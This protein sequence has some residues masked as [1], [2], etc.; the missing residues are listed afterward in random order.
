MRRLLGLLLL[1]LIASGFVPGALC[2]SAEA[3][4]L[5]GEPAHVE[6]TEDAQAFRYTPT[7]NGLYG[8]YLM[9][10]TDGASGRAEIR[11]G[12][13]EIVSDEGDMNVLSLRMVAGTE[14]E[15]RLS[16]EGSVRLEVAREALS[17]SFSMPLELRD[18]GSYSKLIAR[19]GD[20][21]WYSIAAESDGAAILAC[22]PE[23][24]GLRMQGM[25]LDADGRLLGE[26]ET[27]ASGTAV[28]SAVFEE[29]ER[30]YLRL[31]G[32]A[33]GTGKY[34]LSMLRSENVARPE[35]VK[36]STEA[37]TIAGF[38]TERLSAE[39]FPPEACPLLYLDSSDY[40]V[41]QAWNSG[42]AEGRSEGLA[43]ITAYAFGGARSTCRVTVNAEP[44]RE[45]QMPAEYMT[46]TEGEG[47]ALT[48]NLVP[49][50][51]TDRRLSY[52]SSDEDIVTVDKNGVLSA[53]REGEATVTVTAA[54]GAISASM[55]VVVEEAQPRWRALVVGQQE[56][57]PGVEKVREGS[58]RSAEGVAAMLNSMSFDGGGYSVSMLMD[59]PRDAVLAG[60]RRTFA[61]AREDDTSLLYITCHGFYQ[62]GMTFFLMADGSVLSAAELERE[63]RGIPGEIILLIDCC[64]SGGVLGRAGSAEDILRG[65]KHVFAGMAGPAAVRGS[66][67]RV[68][69]SAFLDQDSYRISFGQEGMSTVFARALCDGAGWNLDRMAPSAMNADTDYDSR[70]TLDELGSYLARRASWY[71]NLSGPYAQSV[72]VYPENDPGVVFARTSE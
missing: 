63:L 26:A 35:T 9:P 61:G 18:G 3:V 37:L 23:T 15:I 72:A 20:A 24:E 5:G 60:I 57:A 34:A 2:A 33:G 69:A 64:G 59:A 44:I 50:N 25:L 6:L 62:G 19:D 1:L 65:V 12:G 56:Y 47:R 70:I 38:A 17:R 52:A 39:V 68:I 41:A 31:W 51:T 71:L 11:A 46:I 58:V 40:D 29:G 49:A 4:L 8:V 30:Y 66:K 53:L 21:H 43:V 54:E 14:Y 67:Y 45:V 48:V 10:E 16:G 28:L 22:V 27:L 55:A 13:E 42:F 36:M 7:A 32:Y